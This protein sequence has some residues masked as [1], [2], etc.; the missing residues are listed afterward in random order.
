MLRRYW[1][2]NMLRTREEKRSGL[3]RVSADPAGDDD[4]GDAIGGAEVRV[5]GGRRRLLRLQRA[6][7]D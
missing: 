2:V 4:I 7:T 6:D 3:D 1:F 5:L